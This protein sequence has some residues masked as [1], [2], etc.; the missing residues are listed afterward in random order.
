LPLEDLLTVYDK[1]KDTHDSDWR[2]REN[3]K[4]AASI[5]VAGTPTGFVNGVMLDSFP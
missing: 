4:Y 1:T 5:G 3:W 2:T